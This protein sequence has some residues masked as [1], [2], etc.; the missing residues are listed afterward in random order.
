MLPVLNRAS[1]F[2]PVAPA[3]CN[4]CR[5]CVST[6]LIGLATGGAVALAAAVQRFAG[7]STKPA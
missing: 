3:C 1:D 4:V 7:R 6:N 5:T 2:A